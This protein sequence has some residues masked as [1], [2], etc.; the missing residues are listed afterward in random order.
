MAAMYFED[1]DSEDESCDSS[2][3][4]V[5]IDSIAEITKGIGDIKK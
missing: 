4:D 1:A 3:D 2:A 5:L